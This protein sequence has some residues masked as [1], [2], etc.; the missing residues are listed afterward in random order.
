VADAVFLFCFVLGRRR[1]WVFI[2]GDG[3]VLVLLVVKM[4]VRTRKQTRA[5]KRHYIKAIA[6]WRRS[7]K[8]ED[9]EGYHGEEDNIIHGFLED[10]CKGT[11]T[12]VRTIRQVA[13]QLKTEILDV[14]RILYYA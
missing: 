4:V 6:E 1:R 10:I 14:E 8:K 3:N 9:V 7:L 11:F 12:D 5:P 13:K 2:F